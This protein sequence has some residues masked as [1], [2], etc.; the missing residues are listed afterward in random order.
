M[1]K[2]KDEEMQKKYLELQIIIQ[3]INQIQ[4]QFVNV[5]S[6][7]AELNNLKESV[8]SL[9]N[10]KPNTEFFSQI[11]YNIFTKA[12]T[13]DTNELLVNVGSNVFVIKTIEE[14]NEL[15][16]LQI[17]QIEFILRELED[18]LNEL[19]NAGQKIQSEILGMSNK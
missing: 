1:P 6:Q 15:V 12:K 2:Q 5:Q 17:K 16:N 13:Q 3:Q 10:I 8:V 9:K 11:G 18:K 19:E 7:V 4:Q 14:T